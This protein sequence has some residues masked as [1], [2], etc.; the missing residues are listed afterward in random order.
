MLLAE[1]LP[2]P[3]GPSWLRAFRSPY[4]E[5]IVAQLKAIPGSAWDPK[6]REWR[7]PVDAVSIIVD[8]LERAK[9]A[10]VTRRDSA[11]INYPTVDVTYPTLYPF[12]REGASW[13]I[14]SALRDGGALLADEMGLGKQQPVDVPVLTPTG[15]R[16]IGRLSVGDSVIVSDGPP[17]AVTGI[18][19]Q[20]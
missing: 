19:P 9:V 13:L 4:S 17:T 11:L 12:Q 1:I 20:G 2:L 7:L 15:W 16:P 5:P 10:K 8:V 6:A 18:F 3:S 14:T